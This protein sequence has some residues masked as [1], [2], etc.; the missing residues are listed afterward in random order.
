MT[1]GFTGTRR[2]MTPAQ[3][4][5]VRALLS[6]FQVRVLHHGDCQ[7]SDAD[8][9]QLAVQADVSRIVVHPPL[10]DHIRAYC[11]HGGFLSTRHEIRKPFRYLTRNRHIVNEGVDGLIATPKDLV[12]P[13]GP[14]RGY[15]TWTTVYYALEQ[16]RTVWIVTLDG[17]V[18]RVQGS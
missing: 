13:P 10:D 15:G 2:G 9:D 4:D 1:Y 8:A 3:K 5:S 11:G 18:K 16:Q 7:G 17:R 14:Q 6:E 12:M